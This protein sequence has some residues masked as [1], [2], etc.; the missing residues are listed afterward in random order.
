LEAVWAGVVGLVEVVRVELERELARLAR[1]DGGDHLK[2]K[3]S[4]VTEEVRQDRHD[5]LF[6]SHKCHM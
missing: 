5:R 6:D 3:T 1:F 2:R 4:W